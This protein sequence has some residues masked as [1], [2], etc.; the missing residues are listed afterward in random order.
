MLYRTEDAVALLRTRSTT[1]MYVHQRIQPGVAIVLIGRSEADGWI[2]S[3]TPP[4]TAHRAAHGGCLSDERTMLL[5]PILGFQL[6]LALQELH[7]QGRTVYVG[8]SR[9]REHRFLLFPDVAADVVTQNRE[10]GVV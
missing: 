3:R 9:L 8:F 1:V 10:P 6:L 2:C 4:Q 5:A 7:T